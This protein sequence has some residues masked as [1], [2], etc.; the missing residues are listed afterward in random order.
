MQVQV[1]T[2]MRITMP[3]ELLHLHKAADSDP[4]R[5]PATGGVVVSCD[6]QGVCKAV[7]T[8]GTMIAEAKW[9]QDGEFV[10]GQTTIPKRVC[11]QITD[12]DTYDRSGREL[13]ICSSVIYHAGIETQFEPI[14]GRF[15]NTDQIFD[16]WPKMQIGVRGLN[17]KK[18]RT[19]MDIACKIGDY[20]DKQCCDFVFVGDLDHCVFIKQELDGMALRY[21]IM[22]MYRTSRTACDGR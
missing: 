15:P 2:K 8:D 12:R 21:A 13:I 10:A 7:A 11:R 14:E 19:L 18:L 16:D 17:A 9:R 5:F 6:P 3:L 22:P 4:S 20:Q 1:G